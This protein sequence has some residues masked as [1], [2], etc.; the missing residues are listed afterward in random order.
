MGGRIWDWLRIDL[1]PPDL[2]SWAEATLQT[3]AHTQNRKYTAKSAFVH[4]NEACA[5]S[6]MCYFLA[7]PFPTI[8]MKK[9]VWKVLLFKAAPISPRFCKQA[10]LDV[11]FSFVGPLPMHAFSHAPIVIGA[12]GSNT[13]IY[14]NFKC[15][16]LHT[17]KDKVLSVFLI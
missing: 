11:T 14:S 16:D 10:L 13:A 4:V 15:L 12:R 17:F 3:S 2:G 9:Q 7:A 5:K 1:K 6:S 8:S